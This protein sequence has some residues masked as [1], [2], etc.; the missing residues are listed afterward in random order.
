MPAIEV[1][2]FYPATRDETF[3]ALM[4]AV[5]ELAKYKTCDPFSGSVVFATRSGLWDS[6]AN[7]Q[8]SV[9]PDGD[10]VIVRLEGQAKFRTQ[11]NA[12]NAAHEKCVEILNLTGQII[13]RDRHNA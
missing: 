2:R 11:I 12:N 13:Q 4:W 9:R 3:H 6:G 8:A 5:Q 1:S 10:G 7:M